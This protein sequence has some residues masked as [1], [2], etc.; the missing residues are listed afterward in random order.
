MSR[1]LK[2]FII[3]ILELALLTSVFMA[4]LAAA[5][6]SSR[7]TASPTP[8]PSAGELEERQKAFQ[9]FWEAWDILEQSFYGDLPDLQQAARDAVKGVLQRLNDPNTLLLDPELARIVN[10]DI[11]GQFEGIGATVRTDENGLLV[12]VEPIEN[13]PASRAGLRPGDIVLEVDGENIQG[14]STTEAVAKIRGPRGTTVKLLIYRPSTGEQFTVEIMRARIDIPT[15]ETRWLENETIFY[16]RLREFNSLADDKVR[17]ALK[18]M[19]RHGAQGLI[20]DLR[21]NPGGLLDVAVSVGSEFVGQGI[22]TEERAKDGTTKQ[23]PVLAGGLATDPSLP[24]VVLVNQASASASEIVA[25]AIQDTG[26]GILV[27]TRTFGKG[28]VQQ[29]HELS[30]GSQLRVTIAH[31]FTPNG[32]DIHKNGLEPDMKVDLSWEE[33][34]AGKDTQLE[35]ALEVLKGRIGESNSAL[36]T[37]VVAYVYFPS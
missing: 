9:L 7:L 3:A 2:V 29:V 25:G 22:I 8:T 12:I 31:W 26:R 4:G 34:L 17:E 28:S 15:I 5:H 14:W 13:S 1:G 18:E 33:Y 11:S 21:G 37:P 16:L 27:G 32:R 36:W 24:M 35:K 6:L 10:Q 23:Y 19:Y 30:D 20:L